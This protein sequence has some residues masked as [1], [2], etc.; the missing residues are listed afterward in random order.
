LSDYTHKAPL[1]DNV[2][3]AI[4]LIYKDLSDKKLLEKCLGG[5]TQNNNESFNGMIGNSIQK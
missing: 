5:F 1:P 2:I 4:T 3:N